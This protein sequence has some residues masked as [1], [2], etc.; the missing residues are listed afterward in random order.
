MKI[1]SKNHQ[2]SKEP[3]LL[4]VTGTKKALVYRACDGEIEEVLQV[5]AEKPEVP[6]K[7]GV[8]IKGGDK[9]MVHHG[10]SF[11]DKQK[12]LDEKIRK[13]FLK[14]L[15]KKLD[16]LSQKEELR[17]I[18]IFTPERIK[19]VVLKETPSA[20][21]KKVKNVFYGNYVSEHPVDLVKK[22]DSIQ[23][24]KKVVLTDEEADKI[25]KRGKK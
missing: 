3:T 4:I 6:D 21:E 20:L 9:N 24:G 18:Y 2:F 19:E 10:A 12:K 17:S 14:K 7:P 15:N 5:G 11:E 1:P 16:E 23:K 8:F 22:I 13:D 25:L